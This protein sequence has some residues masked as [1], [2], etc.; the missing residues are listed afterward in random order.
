[1]GI[2]D[3]DEFLLPMSSLKKREGHFKDP[4]FLS[5]LLE[6]LKWTNK[7]GL[8][9]DT[10]LFNVLEMGCEPVRDPRRPTPYIDFFSQKIL[11]QLLPAV[12]TQCTEKGN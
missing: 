4:T 12:T 5:E 6:P 11:M 1:M 9:V 2:F 3:Q 7:N 10:I 8:F